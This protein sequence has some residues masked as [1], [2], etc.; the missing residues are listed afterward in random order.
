VQDENLGKQDIFSLVNL[1]S[2]P[3]LSI[4]RKITVM[5]RL[6]KRIKEITKVEDADSQVNLLVWYYG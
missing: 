2:E 5:L 6:Q 4:S 3:N 1:C